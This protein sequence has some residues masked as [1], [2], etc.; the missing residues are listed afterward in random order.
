MRPLLGETFRLLGGHLDL[1]TLIVLTVW[2]PG[3]LLTNYFEFFGSQGQLPGRALRVGLVIEAIFGPLV[4]SATITT[5]ARIKQGYPVS[6]WL[7][8]QEGLAA[9]WRLFV[10]RFITGLIVLAGLVAL[11]IPGLILLVRYA[12]V[13][14]VAVLEGG[15][16]ADARRRSTE[17]TQGQRWDILLA[18]TL[19]IASFIVFGVLLALPLDAVPG[20]NHFVV[21]VLRDC[22]LALG[23]TVFTIALFVFYWRSR[24]VAGPDVSYHA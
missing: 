23:Q 17:L 20:S 3:N 10:V 16:A 1:F 22:V 18:G 19:L 7:A 21:I 15:N 6:Y 8:M 2:L 12:L 11:V 14:S 9:W 24:G 13:D 4:A 5:L